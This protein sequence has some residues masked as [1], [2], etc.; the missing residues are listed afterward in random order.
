MNTQV[1]CGK[2]NH[3]DC[4]SRVMVRVRVVF[5]DIQISKNIVEFNQFS[6]FFRVDGLIANIEDYFSI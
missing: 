4:G 2:V 1:A 3:G 5:M 6:M